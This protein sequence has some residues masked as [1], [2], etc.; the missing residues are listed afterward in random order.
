MTNLLDH[1]MRLPFLARVFTAATA[2]VFVVFTALAFSVCS[3]TE[4]YAQTSAE[5]VET[6]VRQLLVRDM[7]RRHDALKWLA[8]RGD[9]DVAAALIMTL[10]YIR[11]DDR[12]IRDTLEALTAAQPGDGWDD[13]ILWQEAHPEIIPFEGFDAFKAELFAL[14]DVNFQLFLQRGIRH[15]IRPAEIVW[16]GV[17]KDGIPA[18][19]DPK[20]LSPDEATYI[21]NDELVF[22]AEING[23]ARAYPLRM[24]DWHEMFNDIV[25]GVPVALAYCTLCGSGILFETHVEGRSERFVF[26]SS[27]FLYRSNKLMYDQ[28]THSLWNQFTG[29]PVV[30]PPTGPGIELAVRPAAITT[31]QRWF[32]R[33]PDTTVFSLDTGYAREYTPGH[34]YARYFAS[35]DL[36][37]PA[38]VHGTRLQPKDFVFALRSGVHEKAWPLTAFDGGAVINDRIGTLDVVLIGDAVSRTERAYDARAAGDPRIGIGHVRGGFLRVGQDARDADLLHLDERAAQDRIHEED[39]GDAEVLQS[40]GEI[41]GAGNLVGGHVMVIRSSR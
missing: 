12:A 6:Q 36:M 21:T 23:D 18:L 14:I 37:F 22:G 30:G 39:V 4:A 26:G 27:G 1:I 35:P 16:G 24:L 40:L 2:R 9:A 5:D 33:H 13:W 25:G 19:N 32:A 38:L 31:W 8:E 17:V 7:D 41:A 3:V 29:R 20:H 10:R 28:E 11:D 34:P 15:E